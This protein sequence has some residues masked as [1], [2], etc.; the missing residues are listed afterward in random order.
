MALPVRLQKFWPLKKWWR[1]WWFFPWHW[2]SVYFRL[3]GNCS[4]L[5]SLFRVTFKSCP[6][7]HEPFSTSLCAVTR[8]KICDLQM[9]RTFLGWWLL[10]QFANLR[11]LSRWAGGGRAGYTNSDAALNFYFHANVWLL[12]HYWD[13]R[14]GNSVFLLAWMTICMFWWPDNRLISVVCHSCENAVP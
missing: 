2:S 12:S 8:I 6:G 7:H 3:Q 14:K 5:C 10:K 4:P 13:W 9:T 11:R 1:S